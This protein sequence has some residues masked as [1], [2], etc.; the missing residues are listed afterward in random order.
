MSIPRKPFAL[1]VG[2]TLALGSVGGALAASHREAP[3]ITTDPAADNTDVYAFVSPDRP[4]SVTLIANFIPVQEPAGGPNFFNFDPAVLY[5]IHID[6]DGDGRDDVNYQFRFTNNI[7]NPDTFLYNTGPVSYLTDPDFN[8]RQRYSVTRNREGYRSRVI[9]SRLRTPPASIG[10]R[11]N[12]NYDYVAAQAEYA[13]AGGIKVFAGQRDDPFFFDTGSTFDLLGL[14]PFNSLHLIQPPSVDAPAG[15]DGLSGFNVNSIAIQVPIT[16]LTSDGKAHAATSR[17][18]TIGVWASAS[19]RQTTVLRTNGTESV[20][21]SWVQVSR[22]GN[23]AINEVLIPLGEKDL[24]NRQS[25]RNDYN[26]AKYV[27]KPEPAALIN[28][29]YPSLPDIKTTGRA[30]LRA[31]LMTGVKGLNYTGTRPMDMLRLNTGIAP[32][33]ADAA[34][35]DTG[36]C[37]RTGV[38]AGDLAGFPNGRRLT[39]DVIDIELRAI[40]EGYG[41]FLETNFALP[42]KT[43]N[44]M[45]GD[46]VDKNDASFM[47]DFPYLAAPFQGYAHLHDHGTP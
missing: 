5:A 7:Q 27:A 35:D 11:S 6:N 30:D 16:Q 31:V 10:P 37:Q 28:L 8:Y 18:A 13:L 2:A 12:P 9:A 42:N 25:P 3:Y 32:C 22:L 29:L 17:R 24:W 14:R 44:N 43:P 36:T 23:P 39:D 47:S 34:D 41:S 4:N 26:F 38:L 21:G 20:G 40:A 46:G 19:R 1:L 15:V 45:L 33:T